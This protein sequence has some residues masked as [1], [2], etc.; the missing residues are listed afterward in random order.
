V[1][2]SSPWSGEPIA[3]LEQADERDLEAALGAA[4]AR[5]REREGWLPPWRRAEILR[6]TARALASRRDELALGIAREGGKPLTDA[7]VE[8]DRACSGL[9]WLAG[10]AER[11]AGQQIPMGASAASVGRIAF[12]LR[13]PIGVVAAISAFNHPLNLVVHQAGPAIAAGCPVLVKPA[14]ET[15]LSCLALVDALG[16]AGLPEGWCTALPCSNPLAERLA[17]SPRIAALSFIGSARVGWM[18]RQKLAPGVRCALEHGGAAPLILDESADVERAVP[19][20]LKAG[21]YHSGQVCVSLQ[22]LFVHLA[23]RDELVERL[24]AGVAALRTGDPTLPDT[25]CGPLIRAS[26]VARIADWVEEARRAGARL[27]TGG[28]ALE[29]QCYAPTLLLDTPLQVRAMQQEIFGPVVNVVAFRT[30][31][32]AIEHANGVAWAFQSSIF[33]SDLGN[34]LRAAERL[35]ASSVLVNDHTAFRVDWMPFGGRGPSGLGM[36][37]LPHAV[38]ELAEPKLVVLRPS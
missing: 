23:R 14:A 17:T 16:D 18:L 31:D 28:H 29:R 10:E 9:E 6:K 4:E 3:E 13:E 37:G 15:P 5:L 7:R 35:R 33:T 12:T 32:E 20:I 21:Y 34:A 22:R 27:A 30:I 38:A 1:T 24:T 26:E 19:P 36:G 8:V 11:L 25:D 2:V